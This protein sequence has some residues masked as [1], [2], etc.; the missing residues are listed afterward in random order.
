MTKFTIILRSQL[1]CLTLVPSS[2]T[3][4]SYTPNHVLV[5]WC[6]KSLAFCAS[7]LVDSETRCPRLCYEMYSGLFSGQKSGSSYKSLTLLH[8]RTGGIGWCTTECQGIDTS[9]GK[10]NDQQNLSRMI[11]WYRSI[12]NQIASDVWRYQ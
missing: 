5:R 1:C 3:P 9:R 7:F 8:V 12:Y 4:C 10:D 11:M 2:I 6:L